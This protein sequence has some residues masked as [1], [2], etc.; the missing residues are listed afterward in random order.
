[1][2]VASSRLCINNHKTARITMLLAPTLANAKAHLAQV[3][4]AAYA[5]TRNDLNGAV[6]QLSPY[7]THGFLTLAQVAQAVS[8]QPSFNPRHKFVFELGW[9]A[10]FQH[11][12][13]H[14]G[15]GIF[16]SLHA[17]VLLDAAYQTQLPADIAAGKTG[18]PVIDCAVQTLMDTGYLHNHA[19]M[20]LASYVVHIRK[21]HWRVGAN[22]L[23]GHLLDGDLASNHLSWQWV[24]GTGS[25]KPYVFNADNVAKYAPPAWHSAGSVIDCSYETLHEMAASTQP[26]PLGVASPAANPA[27]LGLFGV[28]TNIAVLASCEAQVLARFKHPHIVLIHPWDLGDVQQHY[29][30]N[31]QHQHNAVDLKHTPNT[32]FIGVFDTAFH[33]QHP[34][35]QRRWQWVQSRMNDL[36]DAVFATTPD[37]LQA[38]INGAA[39]VQY[40]PN[41]HAKHL[42]TL[43]HPHLNTVLETPLFKTVPTNTGIGTGGYCQSFSQ[44]WNKTGVVL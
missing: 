16:E 12:W 44:W 31:D 24:A 22:W 8:A 39:S 23:Y 5:N 42:D 25:N 41:L 13:A 19:R 15:D 43:T 7:I 2:T 34:W 33:T 4:I 14:L 40:R 26:M 37:T 29:Q 30:Q 21:V 36:C 18:V 11:V 28:P 38:M 10:Y 9:R 6:T 32:V 3:D 17:G 27:D 1:M 20:W 35:S